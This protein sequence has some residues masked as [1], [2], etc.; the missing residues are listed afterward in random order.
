MQPAKPTPAYWRGLLK[1]VWEGRRKNNDKA[2]SNLE[3]SIQWEN[4]QKALDKSEIAKGVGVDGFN[5][6][7]LRKASPT[8]QRTYWQALCAMIRTR[9]FPDEY[10]EWVAMLAIKSADEDPRQLERRRDLWVTCHGQKLI[11]R[12]INKE[13][14][15]TS[16]E[17]TPSSQAGYAQRRNACEQTLVIRLAQEHAMSTG[18]TIYIGYLDLGCF[19]MSCVRDVQ[20]MVEEWTGV[21]PGVSAVVKSLH[22]G[23][24]GQYETEWGLTDPFDIRIGNGQGCANGAVR[25]KLLL[26]VVQRMVNKYCKGYS[27]TD[28]TVPM[29]WFADDAAFLST[30]IA[31]LQLA[32]DCAWMVA[33]VCGLRIMIKGKKKTAWMGTKYNAGTEEDVAGWEAH[34]D[35]TWGGIRLPDGT[36]VPQIRKGHTPLAQY[37][38]STA[39]QDKHKDDNAAQPTRGDVTQYRYLGTD[40]TPGWTRGSEPT[41]EELRKKVI[42]VLRAAGRI[43]ILTGRQVAMFMSTAAACMSSYRSRSTIMRWEDANA[44]EAARVEAMRMRRYSPGEPRRQIYEAHQAGGMNHLHTYGITTA[45]YMDQIDRALCGLDGEPHARAVADMIASTCWRLGCR[46]EHPLEW[47]PVHAYDALNED[48]MIEAWLKMKIR[49]EIRSERTNRRLN[50]PLS[51]YKWCVDKTTRECKGPMLWEKGTGKTVIQDAQQCPYE[52]ALA[53]EGIIWW[54][55]VTNAQTGEWKRWSELRR[56][57]DCPATGR[58]AEAYKRTLQ[59]LTSTTNAAAARE[60]QLRIKSRAA[61]DVHMHGDD[62]IHITQNTTHWN[63][64]C[65]HASRRTADCYGGWEYLVQWQGYTTPTWETGNTLCTDCGDEVIEQCAQARHAAQVLVSLYEAVAWQRQHGTAAQRNEANEAWKLTQKIGV[66]E[67]SVRSMYNIFIRHAAQARGLRDGGRKTGEQQDYTHKQAKDTEIQ[68]KPEPWCTAHMGKMETYEDNSNGNQQRK[69]RECAGL[70]TCAGDAT[71]I[72][73]IQVEIS[74][75][76]HVM[77]GIQ[78]N[79]HKETDVIRRTLAAEHHAISKWHETVSTPITG[80]EHIAAKWR[81]GDACTQA[82]LAMTGGGEIGQPRLNNDVPTTIHNVQLHDPL[83]HYAWCGGDPACVSPNAK[84]LGE[85]YWL[86]GGG[87]S[88]HTEVMNARINADPCM[89]VFQRVDE[90]ETDGPG[91]KVDGVHIKCDAKERAAIGKNQ[92]AGYTETW[93]L[94]HIALCL[95][96]RHAFTRVCATDGS[97]QPATSQ[98]PAYTSYGIWRGVQPGINNEEAAVAAGCEGGAMPT[99]SIIQDAELYAIVVELRQAVRTQMLIS[100]PHDALSSVIANQYCS[101]SKRSGDKDG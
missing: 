27:F 55:D 14:E 74:A 70:S 101:D 32:Y 95:H 12:M 47:H 44:I 7:L 80:N 22:E 4:F 9:E 19:F 18:G 52:K 77:Q 37:G 21:D 73:Q 60:W 45:S 2:S 5:S 81:A 66:T 16:D 84:G 53:N 31:G 46:D 39:S 56:E 40:V 72:R 41:R 99:G 29:L 96:L 83:G 57:L 76:E 42:S 67:L 64:E 43:P 28:A 85:P 50:G 34:D 20:W 30:D 86:T 82:T 71:L 35:K 25:S 54:T 13:Y 65:I 58:I 11:M 17:V 23:V 93:K 75:I 24:T 61:L 100:Q 92:G 15:R 88:G 78:G 91:I 90:L 69:Q 59:C 1:H 33:T 49:M 87:I 94:R 62:T 51:D 98:Q 68:W 8:I 36:I 79:D 48:M 63:I 97:H 3:D 26:T 89:R 38:T 10:R 6:Y